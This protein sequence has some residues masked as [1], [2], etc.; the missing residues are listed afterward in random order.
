MTPW[1]V[2]PEKFPTRVP[3][4]IRQ[5]LLDNLA[6]TPDVLLQ[7]VMAALPGCQHS[8]EIVFDVARLHLYPRHQ[9][10][11]VDWIIKCRNEGHVRP[12][13]GGRYPAKPWKARRRKPVPPSSLSNCV[14]GVTVFFLW[15]GDRPYLPMEGAPFEVL[16]VFHQYL[17][18]RETLQQPLPG[19]SL[20][21]K[22]MP[23]L[24]VAGRNNHRRDF[25]NLLWDL[26]GEAVD[27]GS[28]RRLR[29]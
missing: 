14:K 24:Q 29:R 17:K 20:F 6:A 15:L 21:T 11:V 19:M 8:R 22:D 16:G 12:I 9:R 4:Q 23:A 28:H 2:P 5:Q 26:H 3:F 7:E 10:T 18:F 25:H 13:S 27:P 1:I